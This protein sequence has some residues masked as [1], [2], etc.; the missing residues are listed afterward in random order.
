MISRLRLI[1]AACTVLSILTFGVYSCRNQRIVKQQLAIADKIHPQIAPLIKQAEEQAQKADAQQPAIDAF[2]KENA[3]LKAE[4]AR[5][6]QVSTI[7]PTPIEIKQDQVIQVQDQ[8][9][10]VQG[11][12]HEAIVSSHDTLRTST[13]LLM[14]ENDALRN[15]VARMP[16]PRP[17]AVGLLYGTDKTL[18]VCAEYDFGVI[19]TGLDVVRR[20]AGGTGRTTLE[21]LGRV[22]W[23]F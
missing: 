19:R 13:K 15:A 16:K 21:A 7:P 5:L 14:A 20:P 9:L 3:R 22:M 4:L 11:V 12:Q 17:W 1:V 23:R 18:G 2:R 10:Q 8:E 6:K